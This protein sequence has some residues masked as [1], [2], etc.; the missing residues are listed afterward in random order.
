MATRTT[1]LRNTGL[2]TEAGQSV[3]LGRKPVV[4]FARYTTKAG[5]SR[6]L[7]NLKVIAVTP[8]AEN[9]LVIVKTADALGNVRSYNTG[10]LTHT[11]V[12]GL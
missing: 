5:E 1:V 12:T 11:Q 10:R 8:A 3:R 7:R 6:T 2:I 4:K 9:G